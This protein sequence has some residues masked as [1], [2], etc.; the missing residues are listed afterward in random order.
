LIEVGFT[1]YPAIPYTCNLKYIG[2]TSQSLKLRYQEHTRYIRSNNPQSAYALH[3]L[4]N[5][6]E[7]GSIG[8]TMHLLKPIR[9]TSL[10]LP[11]EQLYIVDHSQRGMLIPEQ[12]ASD[13]NPL[14][15][16]AVTP[17]ANLSKT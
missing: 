17:T 13:T 5:R 15:R 12:N 11:F 4:H 6:H 7:Y 9:K 2:Q 16:L 3:I 14:V 10:L 1:H 8:S